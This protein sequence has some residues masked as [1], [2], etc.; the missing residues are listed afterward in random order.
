MIITHLC[1]M[2]TNKICPSLSKSATYDFKGRGSALCHLFLVFRRPRPDDRTHGKCHTS[3]I[4]WILGRDCRYPSPSVFESQLGKQL[5]LGLQQGF[6]FFAQGIPRASMANCKVVKQSQSYFF[7]H[8]NWYLFV[9]W[10]G[11]PETTL[12]RMSLKLRPWVGQLQLVL[13]LTEA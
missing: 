8:G 3:S 12:A 13:R 2:Y 5:V 7:L 10:A 6:F 9:S 1:Y 4:H 11:L